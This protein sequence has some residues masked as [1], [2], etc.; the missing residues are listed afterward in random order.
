MAV[1]TRTIC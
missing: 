1:R